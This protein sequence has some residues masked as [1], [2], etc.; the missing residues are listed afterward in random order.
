MATS[1]PSPSASGKLEDAPCLPL[2]PGPLIM[3]GS[4]AAAHHPSHLPVADCRCHH[5][6]SNH[7]GH[8][9]RLGVAD[10]AQ[11]LKS[12]CEGSAPHRSVHEISPGLPDPNVVAREAAAL[13]SSMFGVP[14]FRSGFASL[15]RG[16]GQFNLMNYY[17]WRGEV[18]ALAVGTMVTTEPRLLADTS[19]VAAPPAVRPAVAWARGSV[20][21]AWRVG[22]APPIH[23]DAGSL[24]PG[25]EPTVYTGRSARLNGEVDAF[26]KDDDKRTAAGHPGV[27]NGRGTAQISLDDNSEKKQKSSEESGAHPTT[28]DAI[29]MHIDCSMLLTLSARRRPHVE[30]RNFTE[31]PLNNSA[32]NASKFY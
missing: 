13:C 2:A 29:V 23:W 26:S 4:F 21:S 1:G 9:G 31:P 27:I 32:G 8:Y 7:V 5:G 28:V 14:F 15:R 30:V 18:D 16:T 25:G 3:S 6:N 22:I 24:R 10:A 11:H 19:V 17:C 20:V 12:L